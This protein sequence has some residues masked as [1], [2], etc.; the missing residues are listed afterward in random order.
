MKFA[1]LGRDSHN[2]STDLL[3]HRSED[4]WSLCDKCLLSHH[5]GVREEAGH[6]SHSA[7]QP[8]QD[9]IAAV[10][11]SRFGGGA[12]DVMWK[13]I[14][15]GLPLSREWSQLHKVWLLRENTPKQK[16]K[17][18]VKKHVWAVGTNGA[19]SVGAVVSASG[20]QHTCMCGAPH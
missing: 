11:K 18:C 9:R 4:Y 1:M 20:C 7:A 15:R 2:L 10:G 5:S 12:D 19:A 8:H 13:R 6:G 3:S 17:Y 16:V 14:R